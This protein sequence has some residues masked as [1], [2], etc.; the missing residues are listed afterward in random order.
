[1]CKKEPKS[2]SE[3]KPARAESEANFELEDLTR[4]TATLRVGDSRS[5]NFSQ[6]SERTATSPFGIPLGP[7]WQIW[8]TCRIKPRSQCLTITGELKFLPDYF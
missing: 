4:R 2:E 7:D 5:G 3:T 8:I 6:E 1:M